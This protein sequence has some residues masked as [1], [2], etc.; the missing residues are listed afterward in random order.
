MS[1]CTAGT[2]L[3]PLPIASRPARFAS[4]SEP[5]VP[6]PPSG[7]PRA[8]VPRVSCAETTR[9]TALTSAVVFLSLDAVGTLTGGPVVAAVTTK[10]I[11]EAVAAI[12]LIVSGTPPQLIVSCITGEVVV[13]G[14]SD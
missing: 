11:V 7:R 4:D 10:A 6:A 1:R 14:A 3:C 9:R 13:V 8:N 5:W 2:R 12:Q